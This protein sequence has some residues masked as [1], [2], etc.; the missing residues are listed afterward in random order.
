MERVQQQ[1]VQQSVRQVN[2]L[3]QDLQVVQTVVAVSTVRKVLLL[4]RTLLRVAMERVHPVHVLRCVQRT[5]TLMLVHRH[6]R[7]VIATMP[8]VVQMQH[9]MQVWHRVK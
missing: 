1:R 2:T 7:R 9:R 6:A 4:V 5:P 8:T 3:Q